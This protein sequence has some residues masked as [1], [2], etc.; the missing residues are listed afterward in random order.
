MPF[1][2]KTRPSLRSPSALALPF[3]DSPSPHP[4]FTI[5]TFPWQHC[6]TMWYPQGPHQSHQVTELILTN[7]PA[8]LTRLG[9]K[10]WDRESRVWR[11]DHDVW[12]RR[13]PTLCKTASTTHSG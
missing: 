13:I 2:H 8:A 6:P 4:L 10:W 11:T 1:T 3:E 7:D 12:L 5:K 9:A